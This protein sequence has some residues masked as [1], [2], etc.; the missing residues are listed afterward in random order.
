MRRSLRLVASVASAAVVTA[1]TAVLP[2]NPA[3]PAEPTD[4]VPVQLSSYFD[5][6]G[7]SSASARG[8]SF[9]GSGYTFPAE[10]LPPG[11]RVTVA[12]VP[13]EFPG[14]AAGSANNVVARGQRI[15]LPPGRYSAAHLLAASSYGDTNGA[16]TAHYADGTTS[17]ATVTVPD[18][19]SGG[20]GALTP[21]FRYRPDGARDPHQVHIYAIQAALDS[22][23]EVTGLTLPATALPAP[24]RASM[25][26][27]ALSV[28]PFVAG[29][30]VRVSDART[31][32]KTTPE[33][34][35]QVEATVTNTG[36]EWLTAAHTATV[37]VEA[38]GVRTV[39]PAT[40][41]RLAPGEQ[42]RVKVGIEKARPMPDGT[43]V[44][45][46]VVARLA[47][48]VSARQELTL[49]VGVQRYS[50]TNASL[51]R[52]ESPDWF[53]DAKFG[54][55]IHWGVYSVPA[56]APVGQ[57]YAEWYWYHMNDPGNATHRYHRETHGTNVDYDDF[58]PR[59][60]A[61]DFD[62]R[63]WVTLFRDAGA[64]YFVLTAKHHDGFSLY[65]SAYSG[66]D[67]VDMGPHAD[68]VRQL[69]DASRQ[70]TPQLRPGL[71]YSMPEW[72]HP[73][74]QNGSGP[75]PGGPPRNPYTGA[76]LPY[77]GDAGVTDYV[78][79]LQVPQLREIVQKYRPDI[80]WCDIGGPNDSR[81]V[82]AEYL[83]QARDR[84]TD[85][86]YDDRCGVPTHDF[87][88]PEYATYPTTVVKKWESSRGLDPRSY[89]YN[90]AT[91][92]EAYMT[93]DQVV[94]TLVD[95]VSKNGNFL[96]DIGPRAD[97]T[98]PEIMQQR[99]RETGAWLQVNGES[100]YNTTYWSRTPE[101]GNLRFTLRQNDAFYITSLT[102]PGEQVVVSS[103]V[104]IKAD[105]TITMLGYSGD[106]LR[107]T[108]QNG[109][110]V[111]DVP[112][113][114]RESGDHAWVFKIS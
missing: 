75:F 95:I 73:A 76:E 72:Y 9:D 3:S 16:I 27:F 34:I 57:Q 91:P 55:F 98:I 21:S 104:P 6:D 65:D 44:P 74:Y 33:G 13:Y 35:Q 41:T 40:V 87:T 28:Q 37:S 10:E 1:V 23:R 56:W 79:G 63:S 114:A 22:S 42:A 49:T 109:Q 30:A 108:K 17:A 53:N 80:L 77:T 62:P 12:G 25:H 61:E 59:F 38:D 107:W 24:E 101:E 46:A 52:H 71:Y 51:S 83:N 64:R 18:W 89:G 26:V 36:A 70:H 88:T 99:L 8:G 110:L 67:S 20:T 19:Y 58:I 84:G 93:A 81:P 82:L 100:I 5:N 50:A 43:A 97:G 96:L 113:S 39:R 94:D 90:S 106:P 2:A 29:R 54:I 11:G 86:T 14:S 47:G 85:V 15:A 32:F 92:D 111:I 60:R 112:A 7:I 31:T 103:P 69:F 66:R 105:D 102:P 68:L 78:R 4:P 48:G 45:G